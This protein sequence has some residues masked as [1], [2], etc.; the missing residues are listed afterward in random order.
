MTSAVSAKG[1]VGGRPIR[2][3]H[4]LASA[5]L[6]VVAVIAAD[7]LRTAP[8]APVATAPALDPRTLVAGFGPADYPDALAAADLAVEGRRMDLE[9]HPDEWLR[10][11]VLAKALVARFRLS[12][13][14]ADLAEARDLLDRALASVPSPAGP[15]LTGA[16]AALLRHDLD[17]AER[18]LARFDASAVPPPAT[19]QTVANSIRC[20][21]AFERGQLVRA[22]E[23]CGGT[24]MASVL[25]RANIAAKSGNVSE[26]KR[27]VEAQLR[28]PR[29]PPQV[30]AALT[31][32]RASLALNE[33]D[34]DGSGQWARAAERVFPGYWLSEAF[35]AQ[36]LALEGKPAEAI[37]RY[38]E[39]AEHTGE[40]DVLDAL[41]RLTQG[42]ESEGWAA[43]AG[44]AWEERA[45]LLPTTYATHHAEHLLLRGDQA[46]ALALAEADYRRRPYP[47]TIVHYAY[48][49]WRA[50][51]PDRAL[52]VVRKGEADGFLTAEMKFIEAVS[53]G[54]LGRASEAAEALSAARRLNPRIDSQ[55]QQYVTFGRD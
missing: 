7:A 12:A 55:R 6:A 3:W 33:G 15:A 41:A 48:A 13:D 43:K 51:Q 36:Q 32:Q 24:D 18:A 20:E 45:Q 23:L 46:R 34:W 49:L 8:D 22:R 42:T 19:E 17:G 35:V 37:E 30:L 44:T 54:S 14:P 2:A 11:E 16:E 50:D 1:P 26:A 25:R 21:I 53:L 5:A 28:L 10:M 29:L 4:W 40:P 27:I 31:L 52:E 38:A 47:G 9:R 39:I